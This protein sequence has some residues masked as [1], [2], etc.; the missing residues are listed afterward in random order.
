MWLE[1][2]WASA[3][4]AFRRAI[5]LNSSCV[6]AHSNYAH[7]LSS[8]GRH[9]EATA[10]MKIARQVDPFSPSV[11][12]Y[13]GIVMYHARAY[14]LAIEQL[15]DALAL[16]P[17]LWLVHLFLGK[18]YERKGM[19]NEALGAFQKAFDFLGGNTELISLKGYVQA[20]QDGRGPGRAGQ[21]GC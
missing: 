18:V 2:D 8:I 3:E 19:I 1:W 5:E 15:S 11:R 17:D 14:D 6:E 9:R 13:S 20:R 10:E 16:S 12:I 4:S 7:V 21:S